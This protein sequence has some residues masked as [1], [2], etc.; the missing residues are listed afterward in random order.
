MASTLH[1]CHPSLFGLSPIASIIIYCIR[2]V[3]LLISVYLYKEGLKDRK[4]AVFTS[5]Y[6]GFSNLNSDDYH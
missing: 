6:V 1:F 5:I 3:F 4:V 2:H